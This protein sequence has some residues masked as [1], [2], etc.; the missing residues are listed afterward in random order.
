[1]LVRTEHQ[2]K[3]RNHTRTIQAA[4]TRDASNI[5]VAC[6][7][8]ERD[9]DVM[10]TT[11]GPAGLQ[12]L[13]AIGPEAVCAVTDQFYPASQ[14][15]GAAHNERR[16]ICRQHLTFHLEFLV[17]VLEFG[18]L[19]PM[20]DYLCW[21]GSVCAARNVPGDPVPASLD[22]LADY[23]AKQLPAADAEV[24]CAALHAARDGFLVS[25]QVPL[26]PDLPAEPD[27]QA[28]AFEAA[29]LG[30][31]FHAAL[32]LINDCLDAERT[33]IDVEL[34]VI[35]PT[36]YSIGEKWQCN[37]VSVA[38]EHL[39]TAI[40]ESVMTMALL[41]S[42]PPPPNG[43]RV[44]LACVA[45]NHHNIGL[46]MVA[47]TF[48]LSGWEVQYLGANV[49]NSSLLE[50]IGRWAPDL[51]GLG[52]SFGHQLQTV[53]DLI[54]QMNEQFGPSRPSVIIGGL[55]VKQFNRLAD[56]VGADDFGVDAATALGA[57]GRLTNSEKPRCHG[58]RA[59]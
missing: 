39:A 10:L 21:L 33:L 2:R 1:M 28:A 31:D 7:H 27:P 3:I 13:R 23:F 53:K 18:L 47:D 24:V 56:M 29:L 19:G 12:R 57:A 52:L 45:G 41:R 59:S 38:Q 20:V 43:K 17:P 16:E 32:A 8:E 26:V 51:V 25:R 36:M 15:L 40:A 54:A 14:A 34:N 22:S 9:M 30:G 49:P 5:R 48:Q 6:Q 4:A 46:R 44:L 55:A 35:Q 58:L 37:E 50:Q 42:P 11:L